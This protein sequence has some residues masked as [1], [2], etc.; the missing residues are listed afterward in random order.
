VVSLSHHRGPFLLENTLITANEYAARE[1]IIF[2][3]TG[4]HDAIV[5]EQYLGNDFWDDLADAKEQF[6]FRLN[7]L[8]PVASIPE[9]VANKWLREGFDLWSA[10][11]NEITR[12]LRLENMDK[13]I[14]SGNVRFDH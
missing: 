12:K 5:S 14:I 9:A 13:F 6:Q 8:T 7:G 3:A 11:A 1:D 2:D 4:G 10:P